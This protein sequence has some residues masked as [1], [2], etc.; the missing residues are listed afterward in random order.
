MNGAC[1]GTFFGPGPWGPKGQITLNIIK[2]QL[3]SQFQRFFKQSLC[4]LSHMKDIKHF[5]RD[6]HLA[7]WSCPRGGTWEYRWGFG[8]SKNVFSEIKPD[9]MC[10]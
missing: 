8:G 3:H 7:S 2:F 9:K 5:R 6:F 10:E 4:V 1:N